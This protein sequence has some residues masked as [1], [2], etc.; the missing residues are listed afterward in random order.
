MKTKRGIFRFV[1]LVPL[2]IAVAAVLCG[3]RH[4]VAWRSVSFADW[5]NDWQNNG[6]DP[7]HTLS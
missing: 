5:F 4:L 1:P 2:L 3:I 7:A 6:V